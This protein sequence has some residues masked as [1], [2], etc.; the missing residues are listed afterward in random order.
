MLLDSELVRL[1]GKRR[2]LHVKKKHLLPLSLLLSLLPIQEQTASAQ[3]S[4][5]KIQL[6][7][8]H[9][10]P[11]ARVNG[12]EAALETAAV[13]VDG[14]FYVPLRW[15]A[16]QL[17]MEVKWNAERRTIGLTTPKAYLEWDVKRNEASVNGK[18]STL[19]ET[20]V[21]REGTLLVKLSWVA[22]YLGVQ[23]RYQPDPS[24]VDISM[25]QG[26]DTAYSE[27]DYYIEDT[28]RNS[29]PIALF[30]T[31]KAVYRIGEP[32]TYSDVSY[33]PDAEG[34]P[35]YRW[36]GRQ[37]AFF[38]S[39]TY[40]IR[41]EVRDGSGNWS[42]P[43]VRQVTVT[44]ELFFTREQHAW[45]TKPAGSFVKLESELEWTGAREL[46]AVTTIDNSVR[47]M[48]SS[49]RIE[50]KSLGAVTAQ[51]VTGAA[52][53]SLYHVN[54]MEDRI[55]LLTVVR[56]TG[57]SAAR[58]VAVTREGLLQP[59]LLHRANAR[60]AAVNYMAQPYPST[61][62]AVEVKPGGTAVLEKVVLEPGQGYAA[63]Q[64][65]VAD[66]SVELALIAVKA[67]GSE[68]E[69][70]DL[71]AAA[72]SPKQEGS[73]A[74]VRLDADAD[75]RALPVRSK[76]SSGLTTTAEQGTLY[77]L[78]LY[79]PRK[80]VLALRAKNGYVNGVL[81]V[82]GTI[83]SLPQGG[84]TEQDGALIVYRAEGLE[85]SVQVEWMAAPGSTSQVEWL[86]YPLEEKK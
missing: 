26:F 37:P 12:S 5:T 58:Q 27:S 43:A 23:Y 70:A 83:I 18:A 64:D 67:G 21:L 85:P 54:E 59:T 8:E 16:Q 86:F 50:L 47:H 69:A 41:L 65:I 60:E 56:N 84:F 75:S 55:E 7:L 4:G 30:T 17:G 13:V 68:K 42:Q 74:Y 10:Q 51:Q 78:R 45:Y 3:V 71:L 63:V 49:D 35:E 81:R 9:Q 38:K 11:M 79:H 22:P 6:Q 80:S 32:I 34:L 28:Q 24:R 72:S 61:D 57:S 20:A 52:R 73:V 82:N 40:E 48:A 77:D 53:R 66:G 46:P 31:D 33:D 62:K 25:V 1:E 15:V 76:W 14:S 19:N 36:T 44:D 39:G 29:R 2:M